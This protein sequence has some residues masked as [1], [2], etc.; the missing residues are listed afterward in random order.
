MNGAVDGAAWLRLSDVCARLLSVGVGEAH[1][2]P[3][4]AHA[5]LH[6]R[7]VATGFQSTR[8]GREHAAASDRAPINRRFWRVLWS[9]KAPAAGFEFWAREE[10]LFWTRGD[11]DEYRQE[12]FAC[13]LVDRPSFELMI[14]DIAARMIV[15]ALLPHAIAAWIQ[16]HPSQHGGRAWGEFQREHGARA[17]KRDEFRRIW[18]EERGN[19]SRGRRRKMAEQ[20]PSA[21]IDLE[22]GELTVV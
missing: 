11:G 15:D 4:I 12:A 16:H 8:I 18:A 17:G 14:A 10:Q 7:I 1:V 2:L 22:I 3:T 13:V 6:G 20:V 19:P 5:G 21:S 9:P